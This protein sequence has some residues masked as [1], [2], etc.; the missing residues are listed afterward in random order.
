ML[1]VLLFLQCNISEINIKYKHF[2]DN[3]MQIYQW[4]KAY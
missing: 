2:R 3:I 4:R 1:C